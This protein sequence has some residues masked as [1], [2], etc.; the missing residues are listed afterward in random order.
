MITYKV[1][2][3]KTPVDVYFERS[4]RLISWKDI[5]TKAVTRSNLRKLEKRSLSHNSVESVNVLE[6]DAQVASQDNLHPLLM[7]SLLI[8]AV[9]GIQMLENSASLVH[10]TKLGFQKIIINCSAR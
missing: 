3:R 5:F 8:K 10:Y 4:C 7:E 6:F 2:L 9:V 1:N